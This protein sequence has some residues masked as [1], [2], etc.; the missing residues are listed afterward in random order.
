MS[1]A[2][3]M[4]AATAA[5]ACVLMNRRRAPAQAGPTGMKR[6]AP[7]DAQTDAQLDVPADSPNAAERLP[8]AGV[9]GSVPASAKVEPLSDA[10]EFLRG[11]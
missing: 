1:R 2:L 10:Q 4:L 9:G 8:P 5:A 6:D 11:A 3:W 7:T